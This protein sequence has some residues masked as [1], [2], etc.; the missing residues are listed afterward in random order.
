[1]ADAK[2][3]VLNIIPIS[4]PTLALVAPSVL[5][6]ETMISVNDYFVFKF[7]TLFNTRTSCITSAKAMPSWQMK[8]GE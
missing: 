8:N 2:K 4:S 3:R 7:N 1:M 5:D 6:G